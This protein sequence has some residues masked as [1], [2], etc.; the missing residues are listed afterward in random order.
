ME[1]FVHE[2]SPLADYLEGSGEARSDWDPQDITSPSQEPLDTSPRNFAPT[3][4][5]KLQDRIRSK[6]PAPLRLKHSNKREALARVQE[7]CVA[8]LSAGIG[9]SD[10]ERF[11]EQFGY[12]VVASQLLNEPTPPSYSSIT[13]AVTQSAKS[14]EGQPTSQPV[15]FDLYGAVFSALASFSVVW[16]FHATRPRHGT[17]WNIKR[18]FVFVFF[19]AAVAVSFYIFARR[20]WLKYIRHE[21]LNVATVLVG[22]SQNFDSVVAASVLL[23]QEVELV[24]RGYRLSTP[25]PPVTR[26]EDQTQARR[27]LKLRR[28]LSKYMSELLGQYLVAKKK[29]RL[30]ADDTNLGKYYDIYDF[31]PEELDEAE[32]SLTDSSPEDK[33][34]LRSLRIL[35]TRL[36]AVRKS[37]LCCLLALPADGTR[38]DAKRWSVAIEEMQHLSASSGVYIQRLTDILHEQDCDVMETSPRLKL[39][40]ATRERH[41]AQFRRLNSLSQGIRSLHAKMHLIREESNACLEKSGEDSE[42]NTTLISQYES[43]GADLRGL[44]QE[45]EAGK[46]TLLANI[47]RPERLSRP[48]SLL[49]SPAS[50]TFSLGGA[51]AVDGS[52]AAALRALNGEDLS[53]PSPD[54]NMDDEEVF[55]AVAL[56]RKRSSMT[57]EARIARVKE[58]RAKQAAARD[59]ADAN[60]RMLREL[61]T[62][63]KLRPRGRGGTRVTSI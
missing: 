20:Q 32:L 35:F 21:A 63:I 3:G 25:M 57:R 5:T 50:P 17:G 51:T 4:G 42:L 55:E 22:N 48:S 6:L 40:P 27:C 12:I 13:G 46:S 7:A 62:V 49:K 37:M 14:T 52:P 11:L 28:V 41:R 56:P 34:S 58:D 2:D 54:H 38:L 15:V 30:Y 59:R 53:L 47:E 29:L 26:L 33:A 31:S 1:T 18:I 16:L 39:T 24:S 23:I 44:L 61:E 19:F 60:T 36:Y 9:K 43:I 45:W 8:A 10:N